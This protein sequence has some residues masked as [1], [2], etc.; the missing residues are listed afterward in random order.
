[1]VQGFGLPG[2]KSGAA[3]PFFEETPRKKTI[4]R[5]RM[6]EKGGRLACG[7]SMA[8]WLTGPWS[9]PRPGAVAMA[10]VM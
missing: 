8:Q 1:M 9:W 10:F 5:A 2:I 6:G 3:H 4:Q 7:Y